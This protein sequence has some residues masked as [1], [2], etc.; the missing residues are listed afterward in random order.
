M[1]DGDEIREGAANVFF[2]ENMMWE[3]GEKGFHIVYFF[4]SFD[5]LSRFWRIWRQEVVEGVFDMSV[6]NS[7]YW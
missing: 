5:K 6:I 3:G 7:V 2:L 1:P 4:P